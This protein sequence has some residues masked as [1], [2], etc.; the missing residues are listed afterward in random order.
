MAVPNLC[1]ASGNGTL[2]LNLHCACRVRIQNHC[3]DSLEVKVMRKK[4]SAWLVVAAGTVLASV[5]IVLAQSGGQTPIYLD[6]KRPIEERIDDLMSRMTLKEKVGQLNLPA[7]FVD[8][9]GKDI[10]A[11]VEA[12]RKFTA[13]TYTQEIG[14]GSGFFGLA[15]QILPEGT[16]RQAEY[17]NEL[18]KIALTQTRL[19]IPLMED[20]EGT[21]GAMF[22]GATVFPEGLAVGS[23]FDLD[24]VQAIYAAAAEEARAVGIHMLSTLV[25]E[26]LRDPRMGRNEEAYTED[27]Y[28]YMRIGEAIVRATQGYDISAPDK[29]IAVLTDFPTQSEPA[30][31]LERGAIEVSERSLR[32]NFLPPWI[33]AITKAGG[34]GVMAGYP[35]VEDVPAHASVKWMNDVLRQEIGFKGI[36]ESEGDGFS[37]LQYEHIVPTQKEAGLLALRA[38]VDLN[39]TYEPAYMGPLVESVEEG[40]VP[41]ALVDRAVRRVLEMKFRLGLFESPYVDVDHA[42]QVVHSQANQDLA[43][44]AGR[45]GIV[46]LKNDK[47]LLPL[48]KDLKSVAVIGPNADDVMNQL[49]DYSPIKVLQHV[50]T[51]I[52]GIKA[53]VSPQTKVT[54]VRGCEVTGTDKSGFADAVKAAKGADVAIVVVGERQHITSG[55]DRHRM[56][57]DG[58][59]HDVASL[60]LSGVQED[61]IQAVFETGTPTV[62]VLIN[63][64]PLSTRWTSEQ[65]PALVEAW[66]PGE[67]GGEAVADVLFGNYNPTGRL[68]IS[69]PRHSGQLPVYYNYKPSKAYWLNRGWSGHNGYVDM[70][71]TPLYPFGYGLSFT[72]YE[73]SN[74]RIEPAEIHPGGEARVTLDVKNTGDRAGVETV[75]LYIHEKYAPVST[76]VKQ[77]R[78]FERVALQPGETKPVTLRL[79]PEDLQLLDIDMRWR[80]VP[81]DFEIM[82]GKSSADVPRQ[83]IL[84]VTP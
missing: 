63:G 84:K 71:A 65:V 53:A 46:L 30:S 52:E 61:L 26:T 75:Q 5:S 60:D 22:S 51:M 33:G 8:R 58:E 39:I 2:S 50:M 23:S 74:L 67:R 64:R 79:T 17:F 15:G 44:R 69:V 54:H 38:G 16:R 32:E 6:A 42:V 56:E 27:P 1:N 81:G 82:V 13:G 68:A 25:M 78:G 10:P 66:E 73:Y 41:M 83:R 14:P 49:G 20:E 40:R 43:L 55:T 36:V 3:H 21:H 80:V 76:P 4:H 7:F 28:L 57:T 19:K 35:E 12:C 9:L 11:K 70:P 18:Q 47:N 31:G 77:L 29:V 59:G 24:L 72:N 48:K 37:T 62:V 45:E 34:L